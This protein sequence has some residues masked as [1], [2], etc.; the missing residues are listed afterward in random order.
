MHRGIA[1]KISNEKGDYHEK[2]CMFNT[3]HRG[4]GDLQ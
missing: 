4:Y 1:S 2:S 3:H